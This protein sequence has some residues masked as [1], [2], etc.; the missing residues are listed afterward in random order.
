MRKRILRILCTILAAV[1][2][3]SM[4]P[5]GASAESEVITGRF[6]YMPSFVDEAATDAYYYSDGYFTAPSTQQNEHLLTMSMVLALASME[7]GGDSYITALFNDIGYTDIQTDDMTITPTKDTIGTAIAHKKIDGHDVVAVSIRGNKYGAE[8]A[9]NLT[10]GA[11]GNIE[12]FDTASVKVIARVKEY[13]TAHNLSNVKLWIAGYSR[14]GSAADLTGVYI[15]EHLDEF[16]TAADDLFVYC[17]E[18]PRCCTSDQVY[19][20]IY[21]V[22]NKNDVITDVYPVSW[23]MYTNGVDIV[24]GEDL[25]VNKVK[26]D[27]LDADK[28]VALGEMPMDA[29][30]EDFVSFLAD[31]LTREKFSGEFDSAVSNLL[32]LYFSESSE[33]WS[34]VF[35]ALSGSLSEIINNPRARYI[36]TDEVQCGAMYH[37]SDA[38]YRQIADEL[39]IL[40]KELVPAGQLS[41]SSEEYQEVLDSI[42][43]LI[44]TLG[45]VLVKD[46]K[47]KVGVD[48]STVLPEDYDDPTYDPQTAEEKI[49]TYDQY[50]EAEQNWTEDPEEPEEPLTD[51]E[52]GE[53]DGRNDGYDRGYEDGLAGNEPLTEAPLPEDAESRSQEYLDAYRNAYMSAYESAYEYGY[54]DAHPEHSEEYYRGSNDADDQVGIDAKKDALTQSYRA[55]YNEEPVPKDDGT[56]YSQD[57]L[58]GYH[59]R[60]SAFYDGYYRSYTEYFEELNLYHFATLFVNRE[61]IIRQHYP[62]TNW[63]LVK[64]MDPYY[65]DD[66]VNGDADGDGELNILDA[67]RI[68]R[69]LAEL[70]GMDGSAYTGAELTEDQ[71][72]SAD[73]DGDGRVT[74]LD[75]TSIQ[76]RLAGMPVHYR[77]SAKID[78]GK[79]ENKN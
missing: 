34:A 29:F 37:N 18:A 52:L 14:A 42:Y 17:F 9:S 38:M 21:C 73:A 56:P 62:Q 31:E 64:A 45:P 10:A 63:A 4:I 50:V 54:S 12:G 11:E 5:L 67:T 77:Q 69:W 32:E 39:E 19:D 61:A 46:Y 8:W 55:S 36:L 16:G 53:E 13:F 15:N 44:R 57:Y 60:Y 7:I 49:L 74:I 66:T 68:Q 23:G 25:T 79:N 43:P 48:Y 71:I 2:L 24:I 1:F 28:I 40:L 58:E 72:K 3:I 65:G 27:L 70:C 26:I 33:A 20:N 30:N 47:Y 22:R 35:D 78:S 6:T 41:I 59:S 76:R 51:A 75:A